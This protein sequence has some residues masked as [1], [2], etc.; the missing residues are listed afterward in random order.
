MRFGTP[1]D[2][3]SITAFNSLS[4]IANEQSG[5]R[6]AVTD[7]LHIAITGGGIGGLTAALALRARGLTVTVFEQ[8]ETPRE[9]GAGITLSPNV[10]LLLN[11]I[12]LAAR[13]ENIN[14][15]TPSLTLR[16]SRGEVFAAS[17]RPTTPPPPGGGQGYMLHRA[18]LLNLLVNAQPEGTLHLGHRCIGAKEIEDRVRLTFASGATADADILVGADG[19]HSLVQREIGQKTRPTSEGIMAYRGLIPIDK[20]SWATD[21]NGLTMWMGAGRSFL[22]FP[23][24]RGRL[25][26]MVAFV[27]TNWDAEESWSAP[28]DLKALAAE[29][30]GWDAPVLETIDALDET[31]R[32][33]IYDRVPLPYWSTDR[34]TLLGDAAHPMVPHVGQGASQAIEDGFALAVLLEDAER[35]DIPA[36]LKAYEKLRLGRTSQVQA[37]AREAGRFYRSENEDASERSRLMSK[38][39]SASRWIFDY[40]VEQAAA[41]FS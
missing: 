31:F 2:S 18:E 27:P 32:W 38:W 16:T 39:M 41:E 21:L 37:V 20:V 23:V 17:P 25:I 29:Y 10:A 33:G 1:S 9:V 40:D 11:R 14:S 22:C 26:N 15:G 19:I 28:G 3:S 35:K 36:R 4:G 34:M 8:A 30:D 5:E 13:L 24:S 6:N 7:K 12:G